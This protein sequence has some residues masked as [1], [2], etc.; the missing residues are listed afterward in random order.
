MLTSISSVVLVLSMANTP[1]RSKE[2]SESIE[3]VKQIVNQPVTALPRDPT[4]RVALYSPGRFHE[5][6]L[7][8]D[9]LNVDIRRTRQLLYERHE[10][11]TSDLNPGV[12]FRGR[13]LEFNPMTKY[14]YTDRSLPKKRLTEEEMLEVNR[15]YRIIG[16]G[17]EGAA[18]PRTPTPV[19]AAASPISTAA[20]GYVSACLLVLAT[21][22]WLYRRARRRP[23]DAMQRKT[24]WATSLL[25]AALG[26]LVTSCDLTHTAYGTA[27][28]AAP[29][30]TGPRPSDPIPDRGPTAALSPDSRLLDPWYERVFLGSYRKVGRR[31]PKWDADAEAFI[32]ASAAEMMHGSTGPS[33]ADLVA[34]G[35][36]LRTAG[37]DDPTILYLAA[38]AEFNADNESREASG[39]FE[40]AVTGMHEVPYPRAAAFLAAAGLRAD[41][42]RR[43]EG[44]GKREELAPTELRWF[45]ESL[46]DGSYGR[47]EDVVLLNNLGRLWVWS[48]FFDKNRAAILRAV[49][50]H[51]WIDPWMRLYLAGERALDDAWNARGTKLAHKV[52]QEGW[53]GFEASL[54]VARKALTASWRARRDRPEAAAAMIRV[55]MAGGSPGESPRLWFDRSVSA[56]FDYETAYR[57]LINA[58]RTRWSGDPAALPAFARACAATRRFDTIVPFMAFEAVDQLEWDLINEA[59]PRDPESDAGLPFPSTRRPPSVYR[60]PELYDMVAA[61][62]ERYRRETAQTNWHRYASLQ[63]AIAYKAGRYEEARGFLHD[64]GGVLSSEARKTVDES[65]LEARIEAYAAPEGAAIRRAEKLY[66]DGEAAQAASVFEKALTEAVQAARPY[67]AQRLAAATMETKLAEG[68]TVRLL[69]PPG[70]E[71]W[72]P[73][74]GSWIV[75]KDGSLL[76]TSGLAGLLIIAD[77]RVG[78][79]F[80]VD[81]DVEIAST[82]NGQFQAGI[83]FGEAP[84]M[85]SNRWSS[86]R[87]KNTAHEGEVAYFSR[88]FYF[89]KQ[90]VKRKIP[91]RN[92]VVIQSW[93]G[94]LS[95]WLDGEAVVTDYAPEWNPPRSADNQ[96]G[97]GAYVDDNTYSLRYRDVKLRRLTS[98]PSPPSR[99]SEGR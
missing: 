52:T 55:A 45:L 29:G 10:Y 5:G 54:E 35:R 6:A 3:R 32:R 15:L 59:R 51:A 91:L 16:R 78:S 73:L 11:V 34:R 53:K 68:D 92:R 97:F 9:F 4:A 17:E 1:S 37:C 93:N 87:W 50:A 96:V 83:V 65:L 19:A 95:A 41:Y 26:L 23:G 33:V 31:S 81:A 58:L 98:P 42:E 86:F 85:R 14:F 72:T 80:E 70:L 63:A 61:V 62:L 22:R 40:R 89:P 75:E 20:L 56:R 49:D 74:M 79:D 71:G 27:R 99:P 44:T 67:L 57:A 66:Q 39:L 82:S 25:F 38:R 64:C 13:D 60:D 94:R 12:M 84:S 18:L 7:K 8:P 76:G 46:D 69:P 36:T 24:V 30:E 2:V 28:A 48:P 88:H 21:G 90:S 77:A 47:D 43:N